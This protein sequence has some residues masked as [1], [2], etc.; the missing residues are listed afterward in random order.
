MWFW[1]QLLNNG[2]VPVK[3]QVLSQ[4]GQGTYFL[5]PGQSQWVQWYPG[6]KVLVAWDMYTNALVTTYAFN[7]TGPVLHTVVQQA[8]PMTQGNPA[9]PN[10]PLQ[11]VNAPQL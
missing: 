3:V 7:V 1:C 10:H 9:P 5:N 11:P 2:P 4:Y 6:V 8:V